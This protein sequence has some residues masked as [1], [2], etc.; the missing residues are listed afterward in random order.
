MKVI[1]VF[2]DNEQTFP[3]TA[4]CIGN[5][6]G[7]HLGHQQLIRHV[8]DYAEKT[9]LDSAV[10]TFDP[11]PVTVFCP[12]K[13]HKHLTTLKQKLAYFEEN[14][15]KYAYVIH[16]DDVLCHYSPDEFLDLLNRMNI[17]HLV[18]GFDYTFGYRGQGTP[19]YLAESEVKDFTVEVVESVNHRGK[20]I[21]S[22]S[23]I[24]LIEKGKMKEAVRLLG[25]S[26]LFEAHKE[27]S[28]YVNH[29]NV[30]PVS[31]KYNGI[32]NGRKAVIEMKNG[33]ILSD[34]YHDETVL[35]ELHKE[36]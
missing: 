6:D 19:A 1:N 13:V 15:I 32:V 26:Y 29:E 5:F 7:V 30:L 21:A 28:G 27:E 11:D 17:A 31:G 25:H 34:G 12:D 23:I 14:G 24:P 36:V 3:A 18:C 20:K 35:I 33:V 10:I 4:A 8:L 9:G 16:F 22:S 2:L